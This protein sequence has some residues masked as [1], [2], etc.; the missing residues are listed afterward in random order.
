MA[1]T[2]SC[3][4]INALPVSIYRALLASGDRTQPV[5][6]RAIHTSGISAHFRPENKPNIIFVRLLYRESNSK[7]A[8]DSGVSFSSSAVAGYHD[9]HGLENNGA[10]EEDGH[11]LQIEQVV[12]QFAE[13]VFDAGAV[14]VRDLSAHGQPRSHRV[15]LVVIGNLLPP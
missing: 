2:E 4:C 5:N 9:T 11:I 1:R 8:G 15:P 3:F 6:A 10:I 12:F 7:P 13:C 14:L